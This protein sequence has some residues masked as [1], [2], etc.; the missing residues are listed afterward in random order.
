MANDYELRQLTKLISRIEKRKHT[1]SKAML[2]LALSKNEKEE[3][4]VNYGTLFSLKIE[5]KLQLTR[6]LITTHL[7]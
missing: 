6:N 5:I 4:K 2:G 3:L 1:F 7:S